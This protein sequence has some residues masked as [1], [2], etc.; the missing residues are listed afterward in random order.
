M[1]RPTN[2]Q[3]RNKAALWTEAENATLIRLWTE[4]LYLHE[5]AEELGRSKTCVANY[6]SRNRQWLG[7]EKRP[8]KYRK[9]TSLSN[10]TGTE[11]MKAFD[12]QWHGPVPLKHWAITKRWGA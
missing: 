3:H 7:L 4:G 9:V 6:L 8:T 5:I 2:T 10:K 1:K 11:F 12:V